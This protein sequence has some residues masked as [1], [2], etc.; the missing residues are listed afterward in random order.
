M[1]NRYA[2]GDDGD[3]PQRVEH[4]RCSRQPDDC[5]YGR[6]VRAGNS[7]YCAR[8][9]RSCSRHLNH[10]ESAA[11]PIEQRRAREKCTGQ[12]MSLGDRIDT[13]NAISFVR[14]SQRSIVVGRADQFVVANHFKHPKCCLVSER[15]AKGMARSVTVSR[16]AYRLLIMRRI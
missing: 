15:A 12:G 13:N 1:E 2:R 5:E 11:E 4:F 10:R 3:L 6:D 8:I 7:C 9:R 16:E 14:L